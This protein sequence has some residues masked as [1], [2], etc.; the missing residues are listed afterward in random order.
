[1]NGFASEVFAFFYFIFLQRKNS[2]CDSLFTFLDF[3]EVNSIMEYS[4][5]RKT[6][7]L[8]KQ[9]LSFKT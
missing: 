2:F 3:D 9:I 6:L 5:E 4:H 1:M 7:L 8:Q